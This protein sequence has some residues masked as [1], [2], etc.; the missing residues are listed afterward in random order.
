MQHNASGMNR[1]FQYE[2]TGGT[3][4]GSVTRL[5]LQGVWSI[6]RGFAIFFSALLIVG[7]MGLYAFHYVDEHYFAPPGKEADMAQQIIVVRG[8][9]LVKLAQLLEDEHLVRSAKVFKY[10]VDFSGYGNKIKAGTYT[11]NGTMSMQQIMEKLAKGNPNAKIMT[12]YITEGSTI[13]QVAAQL[14]KQKVFS[15]TTRF[16]ELCKT[17]G[18]FAKDYPL[19]KKAI[20]T[21][22]SDKRYYQLEGYLFPAT[23]EIYAGTSE[24]EIIKKMLDKGASVMSDEYQQRAK[25][26]NMTPD[27]VITL[28]SIIE[29]EAK[30]KDF[31]KVSAVFQNRMKKNMSLGSD[32]TVLYAL[33]KNSLNL[34]TDELNVDSPYNTRLYKGLPVGPI[35]TPG[36]DAIKAV[37]YPDTQYINAGYLY[38]VLVN[39]ETGELAYAKTAAEHEKN[40]N[41]WHQYQKDNG[42]N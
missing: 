13:E 41:K 12:F 21:K 3:Q 37:L 18:D 7:A 40:V 32:V 2:T 34:T 1:N 19:V 28:A 23:Y 33:H 26:L 15:D 4:W 25:K 22:N 29:R 31:A 16:L 14:Q 8:M 24:E 27:Q 11:L 6:A 36:Q 30:P 42:L 35:S 10:Y 5:A 9:S 39:A 17:G 38:F 20:A